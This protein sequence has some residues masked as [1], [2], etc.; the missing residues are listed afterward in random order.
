MAISKTEMKQKLDAV[1][2]RIDAAL[3][4]SG[5]R[6]EELSLVAVSKRQPLVVVETAFALGIRDFGESQIQE[7]VPKVGAAAEEITW[8][9]IGHLQKNKVRKAVKAFPFI[10]SIDSLILLQRVSAISCEE[11]VCPKVFLQVNYELDPDKFGLH[12]EA[13]LPVLEAA[14]SLKN[15]TCLGLMGI[16][17]ASAQPEKIRAYFQGMARLRDQLKQRFPDWPGL[18]SL[19]MSGDF[20]IAIEEGSH[21]I[22]VGSAL[23][24]A[25]T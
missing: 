12:P 22:R 25:R 6:R 17:P 11:R 19:G 2:D 16:P 4:R 15:L 20:E 18:L 9:F 5:R 8:H 24:G 21:F 10:H 23:L 3:A 14:I 13:A 1:N 7:G